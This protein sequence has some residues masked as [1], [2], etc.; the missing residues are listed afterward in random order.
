MWK[1]KLKEIVREEKLYGE[2]INSGIS[3]T[4]LENFEAKVKAELN[5]DFPK[6]Y[7]KILK[8]VNGI[9][10]N[11][12]IIYGVDSN[13]LDSQPNQSINGLIENN[14]IWYE[15]EWQKQY[16]F[17]GESNISWYVYDLSSHTYLELDNPSGN[18]VELFEN[19][20]TM[21]EKILADALEN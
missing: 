7:A 6:E 13:I 18:R 17:L 14:K 8:V 5:I 4:E 12:F 19:I 20:E 1:E 16:L 11:G 9:E 2:Q 21:I 3:E 15:N 10:F